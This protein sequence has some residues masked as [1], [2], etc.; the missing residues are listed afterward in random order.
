MSQFN[1]YR[2]FITVA[3]SKSGDTPSNCIRI[4]IGEIQEGGKAAIP[5]GN[6]F[7]LFTAMPIILS[8]IFLRKKLKC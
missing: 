6:L 3:H 7:L 1:G 5:F 4:Q 2:F 8:I